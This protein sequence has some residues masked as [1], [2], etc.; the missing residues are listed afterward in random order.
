MKFQIARLERAPRQQWRGAVLIFLLGLLVTSASSLGAFAL[1]ASNVAANTQRAGVVVQYGNGKVVNRCVEF[2]EAEI[3]GLDL[4]ERTGLDISVDAGNAIGVAVCK[5]GRDGC[6]FPN[7]PCFCQCQGASCVYWSYWNL[8]NGTWDYSNLG[9]SNRAIHNGDVDGWVWGASVNNSASPPPDTSFDQVC[10][11]QPATN[12]P[13]RTNVPPTATNVPPTATNI[14]PTETGTPLPTE[15]I[16]PTETSLPTE[17]QIPPTETSVAATKS[18]KQKPAPSPTQEWIP[19][20]TAIPT[21]VAVAQATNTPLPKITT[22]RVP[23]ATTRAAMASRQAVNATRAA[24]EAQMANESG[25]I[26]PRVISVA[27]LIGGIFV[28]GIGTIV[29]VGGAVWY[30]MRGRK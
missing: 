6:N 27:A 18:S 16:I 24:Q 14:P 13:T 9:A 28:A 12:T 21:R 5:I 7:Q 22:T 4:L 30:W 29:I 17:T 25:S 8:Q 23:R 2:N 11:V 3:T 26:N 20:D 19:T 10:A 15:T 1:Y